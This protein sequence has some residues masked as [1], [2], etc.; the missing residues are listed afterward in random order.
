MGSK[1]N[2]NPKIIA[3][4]P[5]LNEESY[6]GTV[7]LK[8][9]QYV[10]EVIVVD[11]GSTDQT[12]N[13]ARLAGATVIKHKQNRGYGASIQTLLSE[14][15]KKEPDIVLLLD[16]DSQHNPDEIPHFIKPIVEGFDVVIGSREKQK[17][18]IPIY[19][20]IG[21]RIISYSSFFL[22]KKKIIDSECGF[23]GLSKKA[24]AILEP[25]ENGMAISAEIIAIAENKGL[26]ITTVPV[27]AIYTKDG[28]TQNPIRHGIGV[29]VRIL[30]MISERRPLLFFGIFGLIMV[31]LGFITSLRVLGIASEGG[32]VAIGTALVSILLLIIGVLSL[33][34][35][36]I[37][38]ALSRWKG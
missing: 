12:A 8:T 9:R 27:S 30:A 19:R 34:T 24:I 5:A 13:V 21:Q 4:I 36:I 20:R 6:I 11:D 38:N 10:D 1:P 32:G 31:S 28:S 22:S 26:K 7:V 3:V 16:A 15:K 14:A 23:R 33:F 18:N 35:G 37:L 2:N 29:L 17:A 25:R